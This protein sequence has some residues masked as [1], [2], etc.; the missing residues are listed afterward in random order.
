MASK[1]LIVLLSL[2]SVA[3][4]E[5]SLQAHKASGGGLHV[6]G[7]GECVNAS[8]PAGTPCAYPGANFLPQFVYQTNGNGTW[9]NASSTN[10]AFLAAMQYNGS[11]STGNPGSGLAAVTFPSQSLGVLVGASYPGAPFPSILT[12]VDLGLTWQK[13]TGFSGMP[14]GMASAGNSAPDLSGV[15]SV[16][17]SLV[18]AVGG[19]Q[20]NPASIA[21]AAGTLT[22]VTV[23]LNTAG[24]LG[25][26]GAVY[27]S[28]NGATVWS[29]VKTPVGTGYLYA[30]GSDASGKHLYAVGSPSTLVNASSVT[31]TISPYSVFGGSIVYSGN[32]GANFVAQSAPVIPGYTYELRAVSVLRGTL[33]FAAGGSPYFAYNASLAPNGVIVGTANGGFSWLQQPINGPAGTATSNGTIPYITGLGFVVSTAGSAPAYVGFAVGAN[34]LVLKTLPLSASSLSGAAATYLSVPWSAVTIPGLP[35]TTLSGIVWDNNM[36]G[37]F[38]GTSVIYSTHDGGQTWFSETPAGLVLSAIDLFAAAAVP[39]TF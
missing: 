31:S 14:A 1:T 37:Y 7:L 28:T 27:V 16:S 3:Q 12:S 25:T 29:Y 34:S 33:A 2:L 26:T 20:A 5:R 21:S 6:V 9:Y 8:A 39:T 15:Y 38:Y 4:A 10:S 23:A 36:V 19:Y 17:R 22:T 24:L 30:V 11:L 32:Y 13:V 18:F 35:K